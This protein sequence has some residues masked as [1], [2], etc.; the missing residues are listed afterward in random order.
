MTVDVV[1]ETAVKITTANGDSISWDRRVS[2]HIIRFILQDGS[3]YTKHASCSKCSAHNV[4]LTEDIQE[5]LDAY[6][7]HL[8]L[9]DQWRHLAGVCKATYM[10]RVNVSSIARKLTRGLTSF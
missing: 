10:V 6:E 5:G 4:V 3:T 9:R 8:G 7:E 2:P 1:P